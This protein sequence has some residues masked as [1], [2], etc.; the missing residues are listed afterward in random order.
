MFIVVDLIPELFDSKEMDK[1]FEEMEKSFEG[2]LK[3]LKTL[4]KV[5]DQYPDKY[6]KTFSKVIC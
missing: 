2:Q 6:N 5:L 1:M 3:K 4:N